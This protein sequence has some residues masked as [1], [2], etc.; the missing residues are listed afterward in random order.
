MPADDATRRQLLDRLEPLVGRWSEEVALDGVPAG[1]VSIEW[2]LGHEYLIQHAEIPH[3]DFPDSLSMIAVD[4]A[5]EAY[6]LHYFDSRGVVRVYLMTFDG[7]RWEL[8]RDEP[9]FSELSFAQ[10]FVGTLSPDGRRID[11]TW[12]KTPTGGG[13]FAKDFDQTF[14]RQG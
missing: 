3:P 9:D 13:E 2:A 7:T 1:T 10:R 12:E 11:A 5:G 4:D 8:L 14:V 6:T